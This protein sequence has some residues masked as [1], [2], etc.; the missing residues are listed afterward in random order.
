MGG[1]IKI[2]RD[3]MEW[4]WYQKSYVLHLFIHLLLKANHNDGFWQGVLVKRGQLI[5]GR[6]KLQQATGIS[7]YCI[8]TGL[9]ILQKSNSIIVKTSSKNSIITICNYDTYQSNVC[10]NVQQSAQHNTLEISKNPPTKRQQISTNNNNKKKKNELE[11]K[12]YD[13]EILNFYD[14]II[15]FFPERTKPKEVAQRKGWLDTI[16]ILQN[17]GYSFEVLKKIIR[18]FRN[19][20]FWSGKFLVLTRL[21]KKNA[22]GIKYVDFFIENYRPKKTDFKIEKNK[23]DEIQKSLNRMSFK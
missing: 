1:W 12:E 13:P 15:V 6:D 8:K 4:Q 7:E 20:E 19:D 23:M 5:T 22:D 10:E 3:I 18:H 16:K 11:I 14:E 2:H 21:L 17:D 9:K